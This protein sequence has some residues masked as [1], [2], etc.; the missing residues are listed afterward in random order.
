MFLQKHPNSPH[1]QEAQQ[2]LA[3][4][5]WD[6]LDRK[7]RSALE[8]YATRYRGTP[9]ADQANSQIARIDRD[10]T[11]AANA[12]AAAAAAKRAEEQA[13]ADR[14]EIA[15]VLTAYA[16]AFEKKDLNLL[17]SIW[18]DL[19][20]ASFAQAFRGKAGIRSQ[21]RPVA[22]V[23]L[24]GDRANVRCTRVT[25]QATQFGRQRPVE[26]ARTVHLRRENERWIISAI[27]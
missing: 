15:K 3:Q 1:T 4:I 7:D 18:P 11:A 21:L 14:S 13:T 23:E 17:K 12:D 16:T 9:L 25:E 8:R 2:M 19:P 27:D 22:P 6:A 26:E 24:A 5:E 10:A 20:E